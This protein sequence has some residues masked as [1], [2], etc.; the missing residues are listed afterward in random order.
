MIAKIVP[1]I[2]SSISFT[3]DQI[4]ALFKKKYFFLITNFIAAL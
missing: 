4:S 3:P 2:K 1:S